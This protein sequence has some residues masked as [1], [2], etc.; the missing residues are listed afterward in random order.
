MDEKMKTKGAAGSPPTK[1]V[2]WVQASFLGKIAGIVAIG[3]GVYHFGTTLTGIPPAWVH[4][5]IHMLLVFF[6][7]YLSFSKVKKPWRIAEKAVTLGFL[8]FSALYIAINYQDIQL[9]AAFPTTL[10]IIV[11]TGLIVLAIIACWRHVG[12]AMA[13]VLIVFVAYAF[14]GYLLPGRLKSPRL[15][16]TRIISY[17]FNTNFGLMGSTTGVSAS[18]VVMFV[19]F[20]ALLECSGAMQVFSDIAILTT[21]RITGGPAKASII[22]CALVGMIQGNSITNVATTGTFAIPL[23]KRSGYSPAFAGAVE[24]TAATGGMIMP[25][26][27]GAAAFLMAEYTNTPYSKIIVF[28]I[29]PALLYYLGIYFSVHLRTMK[30]NIKP[31]K[32]ELALNR[33]EMLWQGLTCGGAFVTLVGMMIAR[34]SAN[35]SAF[36]ASLVVIAIWLIRPVN[37]LKLPDLL[38]GFKSGGK[39]MLPVGCACIGAGVV[40]GCIG[41]TGLGIKVTVLVGLASASVWAVLVMCMVVCIILGMGLPVTASY[42]LASTTLSSVMMNYGLGMIPVHMFLLFFATMSAITPPVA[43]ASYASA[44]IAET[45]PN[46]VGWQGLVLVLPSFV[47]PFIFVFSPELLLIGKPLDIIISIISTSIGIFAFSVI[48]EGWIFGK[49]P[50]MLRVLLV[51]SVVCCLVPGLVTDIIGVAILAIVILHNYVTCRLSRKGRIA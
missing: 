36:F 8:A 46:K 33:Q 23:M 22:A 2:N 14:F 24:A 20:G 26:V 51:G 4:R 18:S 35:R 50:M 25:P 15:S 1:A 28:A 47:I 44:S 37:R 11:G 38:E 27:M 9:R 3:L 17:L 5:C 49:V 7:A 19:F 16:Y 43:L 21:K 30:Q 13:G 42:V 48:T 6:L 34:F 41:M 29:F 45:S 32:L 10:D 31:V 40:V 39:G 12:P